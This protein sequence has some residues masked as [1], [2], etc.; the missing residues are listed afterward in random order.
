MQPITSDQI[1]A[2]F[3]NVKYNG[4]QIP[5][6]D[7]SIYQ[8]GSNCQLFAYSLLSHFGFEVPPFRS[9][10]LWEDEKFTERVDSLQ[11]LDVLLYHNKLSS[12]GAHVGLY[13]GNGQ[14]VHLSVENEYPVIQSHDSMNEIKKYQYFIGAK[15]LKNLK[16]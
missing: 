1:P 13:L 12:W 10:N 9:S 4:K 15:R 3:F 5:G 6:S 14:V 11:P 7:L 2:E 16:A 8:S